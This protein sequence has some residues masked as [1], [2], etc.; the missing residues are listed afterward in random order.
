ML[1]YVSAARRHDEAEAFRTTSSPNS[2]R[3][4]SCGDAVGTKRTVDCL[5]I[6]GGAQKSPSPIALTS[7]NFSR[8]STN[9]ENFLQYHRLL[10]PTKG[11]PAGQNQH[12]NA[13]SNVGATLL[14]LWICYPMPTPKLQHLT[15][16]ARQN[17]NHPRPPTAHK[18]WATLNEPSILDTFMNFS[19]QR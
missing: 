7:G 3:Y 14:Q 19:R 13:L 4:D 2:Q 11:Y 16:L 1:Q 15:V 8:N 6:K 17:S 12:P 9:S 10:S 18:G 5:I